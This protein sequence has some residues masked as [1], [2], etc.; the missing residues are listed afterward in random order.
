MLQGRLGGRR[1]TEIIRNR[2]VRKSEYT[3]KLMWIMI[4][5]KEHEKTDSERKIEG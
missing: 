3:D 4:F 5:L 2:T 1:E